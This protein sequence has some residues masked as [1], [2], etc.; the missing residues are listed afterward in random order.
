M[1]QPSTTFKEYVYILQRDQT[2]IARRKDLALKL[3]VVL[4]QD[5]DKKKS[6]WRS[7]WD[8]D[9]EQSGRTMYGGRT[10]ALYSRFHGDHDSGA[11][12][13]TLEA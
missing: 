6:Q 9:L 2:T 10:I 12:D 13:V 8:K 5:R 7:Q 4:G 3:K 11:G 1:C